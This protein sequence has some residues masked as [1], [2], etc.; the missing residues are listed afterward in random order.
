MP[1]IVFSLPDSTIT[2][3]LH[4]LSTESQDIKTATDMLTQVGIDEKDL[5]AVKIKLL[6][7]WSQPRCDDAVKTMA[8]RFCISEFLH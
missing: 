7:I 4:S 3:V 2:S 6:K 5:D 1:P 8:T